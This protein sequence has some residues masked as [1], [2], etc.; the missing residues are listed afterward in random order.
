MRISDSELSSV[1]LGQTKKFT[2]CNVMHF[3]MHSRIIKTVL[4]KTQR[5][6]DIKTESIEKIKKGSV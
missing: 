6:H 1:I 4:M 3:N 5:F 2:I